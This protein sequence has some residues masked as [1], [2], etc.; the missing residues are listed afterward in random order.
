[1]IFKPDFEGGEKLTIKVLGSTILGEQAMRDTLRCIHPPYDETK[2]AST[3][4]VELQKP[5]VKPGTV[6][7]YVAPCELEAAELSEYDHF[8]WRQAPLETGC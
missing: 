5:F 6:I 4:A 1:M 2:I 7:G 3:A 8:I